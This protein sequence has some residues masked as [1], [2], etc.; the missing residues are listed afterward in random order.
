MPSP[1]KWRAEGALRQ[2]ND[3]TGIKGI[4]GMGDPHFTLHHF[5]FILFLAPDAH[6]SSL[7]GSLEQWSIF[8]AGFERSLVSEKI[9]N[10]RL[11]RFG[12]L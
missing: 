10:S 1:L 8:L 11:I 7:K 2:I 3:F 12:M 5:D 4:K 9:P 6:R